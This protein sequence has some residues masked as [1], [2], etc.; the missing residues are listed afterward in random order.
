MQQFLQPLLCFLLTW[1]SLDLVA[2]TEALYFYQKG[3]KYPI[4]MD[5]DLV[6][7]KLKYPIPTSYK[8]SKAHHMQLASLGVNVVHRNDLRRFKLFENLGIPVFFGEDGRGVGVLTSQIVVKTQDPELFKKLQ[9]LHPFQKVEQLTGSRDIYLLN[10]NDPLLALQ[11]A[12]AFALIDGI[13]YSQ[14][15]FIVPRSMRGYQSAV[16]SDSYFAMQWHLHNSG[17]TGGKEHADISIQKAWNLT[18][19]QSSTVIAVID[20]GMQIAHP[21]LVDNVRTNQRE[22]P[23]DQ[24]DNDLNG[25]I[26]D[27][28]GWNFWYNSS[29]VADGIFTDHGTAVGGIVGAAENEKGV[30]GVCPQCKLLPI[31]MGAKTS[32]DA[33][34]FFYAMQQGADIITNSWGYAVGVPSTQVVED[35]IHTVATFGRRGLGAIILFAMNNINQD[36]CIGASPDISSLDDVIAVSG[37][38]DEDRKV[39]YSAWGNCMEILAPTFEHARGGIVTTDLVGSHGYND[40]KFPQNLA[41]A[42]YTNNFGGTSAATPQVAGVLGLMLSIK[43][44]LT[45]NEALGILL[46]TTDKIDPEAA[47]Y[48]Q[49]SGFSQRYGYGRVNAFQAVQTVAVYAKAIQAYQQ[50]L[51]KQL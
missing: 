35:A 6:A 37:S 12:N 31:V 29:D 28:R 26:D 50:K 11:A 16:V 40:G 41:D 9:K 39:S 30:I 15:D 32:D 19:G 17:Q 5:Q 21:D 38:S 10:F 44:D 25:Y 2:T 22:I 46:S 1:G 13:I 49:E 47:K 36:D 33:K 27:Y 43:A 23:G 3:K 51:I 42:D 45:R 48:D 7:I 14:P 34:A 24:K 18:K 8:I 20:G 4:L